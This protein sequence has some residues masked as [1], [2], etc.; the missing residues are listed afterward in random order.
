MPPDSPNE[1]ARRG[2]GRP[3]LDCDEM[4]G[5]GARSAVRDGKRIGPGHR[6]IPEKRAD[7]GT[8][9]WLVVPDTEV[10]ATQQN[11]RRHNVFDRRYPALGGDAEL[12]GSPP[13][14]VR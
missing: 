10:Y 4:P 6:T 5:E 1:V 11:R 9:A 7:C 2:S 3:R 13:G 14:K 8:S 12:M